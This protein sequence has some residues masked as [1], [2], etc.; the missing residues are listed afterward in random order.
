MSRGDHVGDLG[1]GLD[2]HQGDIQND[3]PAMVLIRMG[4]HLEHRHHPPLV[5]EK[6]AI[7]DHDVAEPVV[8]L[9]PA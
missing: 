3:V 4:D 5:M 9:I 1:R 2:L 6:L 8:A 7:V